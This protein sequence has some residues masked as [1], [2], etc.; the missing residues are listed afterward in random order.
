MSIA[1]SHIPCFAITGH[2]RSATS[3]VA[4]LLQSAGLNVGERLLGAHPSNKNGH[5]EDLDF[6]HFHIDVLNSQGFGDEGYVLRKSIEVPEQQVARAR[7]L[8]EARM[9]LG[10]P[11]TWKDPRTTLFLDFWKGMIPHLGFLCIFR[12][13]WEVVDSQFRRGHA[14]YRSNPKL[15]V[16]VWMTYNQVILEFA[17]RFPDQCLLIEGPAIGANPALLMAAIAKKF[18]LA[19]G[20]AANRFDRDSLV[21]I[22]SSHLPCV[23]RHFFPEAVDIYE[24]LRSRAE[25]VVCRDDP[26]ENRSTVDSTIDWALQHWHDLRET[27]R[28]LQRTQNDIEEVKR[29]GK[30]SLDEHLARCQELQRAQ[31]DIE[32]VKRQARAS[33]DEHLAHCQERQALA[34]EMQRHKEQAEARLQEVQR[35]IDEWRR[36]KEQFESIATQLRHE[37]VSADALNRQQEESHAC[38]RSLL[39]QTSTELAQAHR[40]LSRT[41]DLLQRM[42]SSKFW[43]LRRAWFKVKKRINRQAA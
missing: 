3:L 10:Q 4:S 22:D 34:E 13:P 8:I 32:E 40:E 38:T 21:R 17:D 18:G 12:A 19:L 43:K 29:Q 42:E 20:P 37:K 7:E 24:Q 16:Q 11:W 9:R 15:A 31:A 1:M 33:L 35:D 5:Y 39:R 26:C 23:I 25:I 41:Q 28:Q 30:A 36:L 14:I 6:L 27:Q 2:H